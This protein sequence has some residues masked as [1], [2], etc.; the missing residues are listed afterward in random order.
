M[1]AERMSTQV[2]S[3]SKYMYRVTTDIYTILVQ[4]SPYEIPHLTV[5]LRGI[6]H[7]V[8]LYAWWNTQ[9]QQLARKHCH[10]VQRQC[11]GLSDTRYCTGVLLSVTTTSYAPVNM[12]APPCH[13]VHAETPWS[14]RKMEEELDT[15]QGRQ[16]SFLSRQ[17]SKRMQAT[18]LETI[19]KERTL[20]GHVEH[21]VQL[22]KY[23]GF[24]T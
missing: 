17:V 3:S 24:T 6:L 16:N 20:C 10:H 1:G 12:Q 15:Y 21:F 23:G 19:Q 11:E 7:T 13:R 14:A 2:S 22:A 4:V 8:N 5:F 9:N 18:S